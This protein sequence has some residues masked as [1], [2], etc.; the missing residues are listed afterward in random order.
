MPS[1]FFLLP[2]I[3]SPHHDI[4]HEAAHD[5]AGPLLHIASHMG[6]SIQGERRLSV[7]QDSRE[8]LGIHSTGQGVSGKSVPEIVKADAGQSRPFQQ[9]F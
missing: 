7:A 6:I 8:G 4:F 5:L 1:P 9:R 2:A 3:L